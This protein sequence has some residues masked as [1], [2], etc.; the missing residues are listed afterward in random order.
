M[1]AV[2]A[3]D[4]IGVVAEYTIKTVIIYYN[5]EIIDYFLGT[6][7]WDFFSLGIGI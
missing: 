1:A 7:N 3:K 6:G 4:A 2:P 5:T